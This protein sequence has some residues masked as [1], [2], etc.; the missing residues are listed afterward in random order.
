MT[1]VLLTLGRLPKAL[2]LARGFSM[3][4][5]RVI[6]AEPFVRHLAGASRH[7]AQSVVVPSPSAGKAAYLDALTAV[8]EREGVDLVVPVSEETMHVAA[9][10]G[11]TAARVFTMDQPAVL[12]LHDKAGFVRAGEACGV[13]VPETHALGS[14]GA[15]ALAAARDVAVKP[16]FSCS[17]RGVR[18]VRRGQPLPPPEPAVVQAFLPGEVHSSCTLALDGRAEGT[19]IYRGTVLSGS[20]AVAFQRIEHPGIT[21]WIER[22][23]ASVGWTGFVSFDFIVGEDGSVHGI[24]CNPRATS[25]LHFWRPDSI[26][27]AILSHGPVRL[28]PETELQQ[29]YSCLTE[30]QLA[31]F[32]RDGPALLRR[33]FGTRDV[34]WDRGDPMPF[35]TM[36]WTSWRIIADSIRQRRTFGEVATLDVG[37]YDDPPL[38]RSPPCQTP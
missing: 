12:A 29:F 3:A 36:P 31:L 23:V 34:T 8:I 30:A 28:R 25:G 38:A 7:V 24:E 27:Q 9:L 2:D 20:V 4:G 11:R 6:V 32:R 35:V 22:F 26:A 10:R 5:C 15:V 1:T 33:L 18:I 16:I 21:A 37:W 17:G 14:D 19:V 13:A